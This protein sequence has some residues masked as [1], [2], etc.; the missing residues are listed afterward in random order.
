MKNISREKSNIEK[1]KVVPVEL[2]KNT[3]FIMSNSIENL[4]IR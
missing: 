2:L 3:D 1:K 4:V